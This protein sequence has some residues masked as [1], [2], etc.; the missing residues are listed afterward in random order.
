VPFGQCIDDGRLLGAEVR[1]GDLQ[2]DGH[3]PASP[4]RGASRYKRLGE[5]AEIQ[6]RAQRRHLAVEGHLD[7]AAPLRQRRVDHHVLELEAFHPGGLAKPAHS[8]VQHQP[9]HRQRADG[10]Q[11]QG[12]HAAVTRRA[13]DGVLRLGAELLQLQPVVA[14]EERQGLHVAHVAAHLD[15]HAQLSLRT[16]QRRAG[17]HERHPAAAPEAGLVGLAVLQQIRVEPEAGVDE[18]HALVDT[19]HL[20]RDRRRSQQQADRFG[21]VDG[22]AVRA[23][24]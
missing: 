11:H 21:R 6:W 1:I 9:D 3:P 22:N 13:G 2:Q 10:P 18:E 23:A 20:D 7:P 4:S 24:K 19:G 17:R 5:H 15:V 8:P 12:G 14:H 16:Q